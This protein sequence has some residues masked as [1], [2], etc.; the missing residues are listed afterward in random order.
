MRSLRPLV[1][2]L[3]AVASAGGLVACGGSHVA[4]SSQTT[5]TSDTTGSPGSGATGAVTI[6]RTST[7]ANSTAAA[8]TTGAGG[9][10]T[11][12]AGEGSSDGGAGITGLACTNAQIRVSTNDL[13]EGMSHG[14]VVLIFRNESSTPCTLG[15]YPGVAGLNAAGTQVTEARR[16]PSGYLGGLRS[17]ARTPPV[18]TLAPGQDASATAQG[19]S[20]PE[21]GATSC[22]TLHGMLVTPPNTTR[23]TRV[24]AAP[25]DCSGLIVTPVVRGSSGVT[26]Q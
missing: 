2:A 14:G 24:S 7:T 4:G 9:S 15:G 19:T 3:V 8:T 16:E 21:D 6:T 22:P 13:G 12:P 17:G 5:A 25:P 20:A 18:V 11:S 10:A 1:C 26:S 23:S